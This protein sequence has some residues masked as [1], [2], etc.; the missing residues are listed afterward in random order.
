VKSLKPPKELLGSN[1]FEIDK[2]DSVAFKGSVFVRVILCVVGGAPS[3]CAGKVREAGDKE[4]GCVQLVEFPS[5]RQM[6]P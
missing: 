5:A 3:A 6:S 2:P 4:M 1:R